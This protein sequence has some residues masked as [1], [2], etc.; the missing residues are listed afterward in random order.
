MIRRILVA[1]DGSEALRRALDYAAGLADGL[2][3]ELRVLVVVPRLTLPIFFEGVFGA[4]PIASAS[5]FGKYQERMKTLYQNILR[6][7]EEKVRREH[8]KLSVVKVLKEGRPSATIVDAA[9]NG[10][11]D[12]I[13]I[14]SRG[15][16]GITG[17]ILGSTSH[18]VADSCTRPVVIVK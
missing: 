14:G 7:A 2:G 9:E 13:V 1:V 8:P 15:L 17:W 18:R 10:D 6:E 11:V 3:A 5:E 16:G 12:L 4:M